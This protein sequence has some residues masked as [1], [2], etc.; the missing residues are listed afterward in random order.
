MKFASFRYLTREGVRSLWQNRFMAIASIIVL[1]SCLLL[2]GGSYL[3]FVNIDNAFDWVY[4]QNIVAAFT[5]EDF[6]AAEREP[7]S[8]KLL[9]IPNIA[10]V[11]LK[12]K[13]ELLEKY[14]SSMPSDINEQL[15][16]KNP[17][18]DVFLVTLTDVALQEQSIAAISELPEIDELSYNADIADM[19]YKTRH[20]VLLVGG[21]IIALLMLV[22]LFI[23]SNT[24]KLTVFNRRLEISIMKSVGATNAFV[25]FPFVVEGVL[26]GALSAAA[27]YGVTF[28][29][30]ERMV[31]MF[32][33][34]I[35]IL[36]FMVD[37]SSV[38]LVVFCGYFAIGIFMGLLGSIFSAGRYLRKDGGLSE[39][40]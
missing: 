34:G 6:D 15:V 10:E 32:A 18:S 35:G 14:G 31:G 26:L 7:L 11:E 29:I 36:N 16:G 12:S 2:T 28:L 27:A 13:E 3:I 40:L 25:R 38:S 8:E 37:F 30:Y 23:I 33:S 19:L 21:W 17:Y 1:V 9:A 39:L 20:A 24:I 22:S 4:G 5:V